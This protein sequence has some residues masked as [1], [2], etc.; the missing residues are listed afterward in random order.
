MYTA[1]IR[2]LFTYCPRILFYKYHQQYF[3]CLFRSVGIRYKPC[4]VYCVSD[5]HSSSLIPSFF[6]SLL[7]TS[8]I[9]VW[10]PLFRIFFSMAL[11]DDNNVGDGEQAEQ[12]GF[13][14]IYSWW[15][16][17]RITFMLPLFKHVLCY[18][19]QEPNKVDT[20]HYIKM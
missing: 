14:I 12:R 10:Y 16:V 20:L 15:W 1:Y 8:F 3:G 5:S 13:F 19:H 9:P 11:H 6:F 7:K 2:I 17:H 18:K 4:V